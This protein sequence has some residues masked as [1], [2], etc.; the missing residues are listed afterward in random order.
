M[1]A[2]GGAYAVRLEVDDPDAVVA[3]GLSPAG[4]VLGFAS[5]G[6]TRDPDGPAEWELYAV[7]VVATAY[8][9][10]L[11]VDLVAAVVGDRPSSVWV[12]EENARA[13]AFYAR[14]G[15]VADGARRVHEATACP[16]MRMV[17][18]AGAGA[19]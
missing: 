11:A 15:W 9:S 14:E 5:G 3:V 1:G 7:N 8:G 16:E 4:E 12:L 10:G 17:R 13:R 19:H 6:P 2:D 18:P